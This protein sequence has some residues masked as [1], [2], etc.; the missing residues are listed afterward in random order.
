APTPTPLPTS[1][2]A[3]TSTPTAIPTATSTP[4]P[5]PYAGPFRANGGDYS[6]P[7]RQDILVDGDLQEWESIVAIPLAFVQQGAENRQ[8]PEDFSV[9]ARLAWNGQFLYFA[10]TVRDDVHVQALRG[11]DLFNGDS[12]ELWLDAELAED[13]DDDTLN[14]DDFQIGFSPGDFGASPPEGVIWYPARTEEWNRTLLVAVQRQEGG[15][16]LEAAIPWSVL[17]QQPESGMT[18]GFSI[19]ANDNDAPGAAAQQTILM[20]TAGMIWGR[21]TTFSN[22]RLE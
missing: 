20:H 9:D 10:A 7:L 5:T 11:Y 1:T 6:A 13:F 14:N 2:P 22:L 17:N 18:F 12:V 15:Y 21:P 19:N 4:A 16:S 8:N 3:P